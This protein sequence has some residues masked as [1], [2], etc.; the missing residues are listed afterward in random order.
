MRFLAILPLCALLVGCTAGTVSEGDAAKV[1]QDFSQ[2]NYEKAM[3]A[4]GK[5]AC[6]TSPKYQR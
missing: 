4:A 2:E 5:A 6:I 1:R 3:R